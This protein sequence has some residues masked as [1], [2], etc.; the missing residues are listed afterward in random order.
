MLSRI[1]DADLDAFVYDEI[2]ALSSGDTEEGLRLNALTDVSSRLAA[3][4]ARLVLAKPLVESHRLGTLLDEL[5][6]T[7]S[8]WMYRHYRDVV[9]SNM[10]RFGADNGFSDIAPILSG[11]ESNWR[12]VG[13][14]EDTVQ[15]VRGLSQ[16][17]LSRDD[18]A[19]LF[20]YARNTHFFNQDLANEPRVRLQRYADLVSEPAKVMREIYNFAGRD[21]P[22]DTILRDVRSSS[23]GK[24]VEIELS[25]PVRALC[26]HML[27]RLDSH[28]ATA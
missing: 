7:R 2:S 11:D 6:Y 4:R 14:T 12:A 13:L 5:E 22:G 1:F 26:E 10:N 21:Y 9:N 20:W 3:P 28:K 17:A 16:G 27:Q 8:V 15:T 24:G 18:A 19:A 25:E 23:V